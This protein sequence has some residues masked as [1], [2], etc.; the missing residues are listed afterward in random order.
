MKIKR[1]TETAK[2]PVRATEESAGSDLYADIPRQIAIHPGEIRRV[3]TGIAMELTEP[4]CA[5]FVFARSSLAANHGMAP[6]NCVGVID[7]DYRG[8]LIVALQNHGRETFILHPG[9]RFAQLVILP[10]LTPPL[11]EVQELGETARGQG[12]YGSTG[13]GRLGE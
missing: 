13:R 5:G 3:G 4:G 6:A 7:R 1:L 8:E 11:E 12:G 10:V 2:L 9:D